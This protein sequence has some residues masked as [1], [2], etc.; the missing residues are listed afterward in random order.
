MAKIAKLVTVTLITRVVMDENAT[1][2]QIL[3]M[4]RPHFESKLVTEL[5]ENLESIKE[6]TE[7]PYFE[8]SYGVE[9]S[10]GDKVRATDEDGTLIGKVVDFQNH[11]FVIVKPMDLG[12]T[13][14]EAKNII[15]VNI[16]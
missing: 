13:A 1:D 9:I 15:V 7:C 12:P 2:E 11:D 14:Y 5:N 10:I 8:D 16:K 6:D 4:A 3:D